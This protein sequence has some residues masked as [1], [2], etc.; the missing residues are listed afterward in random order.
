MTPDSLS[1]EQTVETTSRAASVQAAGLARR[2]RRLRA[3]AHAVQLRMVLASE[4][5]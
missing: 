1:R 5:G 3:R 2:R 4:P